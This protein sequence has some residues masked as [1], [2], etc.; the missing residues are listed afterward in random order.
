M[1]IGYYYAVYYNRVVIRCTKPR[2]KEYN[3]YIHYM[4]VTERF[5]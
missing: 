5:L 2:Y 4:T 1:Y 3:N